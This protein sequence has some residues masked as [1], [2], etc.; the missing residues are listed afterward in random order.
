MVPQCKVYRAFEALARP[1]LPLNGKLA[2]RY[3]TTAE[4]V[5]RA[6]LRVA[7]EGYPEAVLESVD[8]RRF[9]A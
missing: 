3:V 8:I 9:G 1:L 7:A 2:P 5:G 4:Q 6:M